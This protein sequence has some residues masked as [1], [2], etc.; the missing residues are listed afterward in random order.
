MS[1]A[2]SARPAA[3][4]IIVTGAGRSGTSTVAGA[5]SHLGYHVP[6]PEVKGNATN[7][8]GHFEPRWVVDFHKRLLSAANVTTSD[9]RP[10]ASELVARVTDDQ[11]VRDE[12]RD[13]LSGQLVHRQLVVK[14]PRAFWFRDLW[15]ATAASLGVQT[16]FL[17]ML[18]HPA[19]VVGSRDRH[20]LQG[21]TPR[22]RAAHE[23]G[24]VAGWLN[25]SL[26]NEWTSRGHSRAFVRYTELLEDWRAALRRADAALGL[27][28]GAALD[29]ERHP[30]D[31]FIDNSLHRVRVTWEDMVVPDELRDQAETVWSAL[32]AKVDGPDA[33]DDAASRLLDETRRSYAR[34]HEDSAALALDS[35][36]AALRQGRGEGRRK[37]A[38]QARTAQDQLRAQQ[39][40]L[41]GQLRRSQRE[42]ARAQE[43]A[44]AAET[45]ARTAEQA[46]NE[47]R[48][49]SLGYL[50]RRAVRKTLRKVRAM[51]GR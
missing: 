28:L 15:L 10:E 27:N 26:T 18:R 13:W 34:L 37:A 49:S 47:L 44:S 2:D 41:E 43:C 48:A 45:R 40:E 21:K 12:L 38:A 9:S 36:N 50:G 8:R 24:N 51:R 29:A 31:D 30:V 7:P 5:L 42:L 32:S 14:D 3:Q 19:E 33:P 25:A 11:K 39:V 6:K 17:T 4:L 23:L 46:L 1:A 35:I 20:Y 22:E 16:H